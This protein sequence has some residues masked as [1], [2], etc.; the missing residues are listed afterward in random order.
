MVT[1]HAR[2]GLAF[3]VVGR[4]LGG[5]LLSRFPDR[6]RR[7]ADT[8]FLKC[9]GCTMRSA[10]S[11]AAAALLLPT[12]ERAALVLRL[13][14]SLDEQHDVDA[15]DLWAEEVASRI[16]ALSAGTVDTVTTAEALTEARARLSARRG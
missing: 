5:D 7:A 15:E 2:S 11:I 4:L 12:G 14:E 1:Q 10:E 9:Y 6:A 13:A 3:G 16:E 8:Q